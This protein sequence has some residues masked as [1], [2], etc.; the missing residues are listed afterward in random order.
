MMAEIIPLELR[1]CWQAARLHMKYL[2][3]QFSGLPGLGLL[4][5]YYAA[6]SLG[7][8]AA[9]FVAEEAPGLVGYICGVWD[10]P[11][12][13]RTLWRR[14]G[15]WLA[16]CGPAQ[17][18]LD[19]EM[20]LSLLKRIKGGDAEAP[21][22]GVELRPIVVHPA[23]R[24]SGLAARLA[25]S[26]LQEAARSGF[27]RVHLYTEPENIAAQRFYRKMGFQL[28]GAVARSGKSHLHYE[29]R[30]TKFSWTPVS[31]PNGYT[32]RDATL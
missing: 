12:L 32:A 30:L 31:S 25:E 7:Q 1:H 16:A 3:T 20:F 28:L 21:E 11:A 18:M 10:V 26:L 15:L 5:A 23:A 24:G 9:G 19:P 17:V 6:V 13:R 4:H 8:G 14:Q 22:P 27:E 29:R 2:P